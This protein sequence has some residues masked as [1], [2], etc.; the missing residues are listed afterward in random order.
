MHI[1]ISCI[2]IIFMIIGIQH[3]LKKE[4]SLLFITDKEK[5]V[6]VLP[7][8]AITTTEED[9]S[10]SYGIHDDILTH[11]TKIGDLKLFEFF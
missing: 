6:A 11:L 5:S 2:A 10:F 4:G 8:A 9:E 3:L 7:F 1:L